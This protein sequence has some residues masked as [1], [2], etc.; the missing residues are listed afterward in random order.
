M[1][2]KWLRVLADPV[3]YHHHKGFVRDPAEEEEE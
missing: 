2:Y 3:C 1:S